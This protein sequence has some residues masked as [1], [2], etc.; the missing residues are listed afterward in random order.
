MACRICL[1]ESG[2]FI[3]PCNCKGTTGKVHTSCLQTWILESRSDRC[4]I[5]KHEYNFKEY[6]V[7]KFKYYLKAL[8]TLKI[9]LNIWL[10]VFLTGMIIAIL[11]VILS[12]SVETREL[13]WVHFTVVVCMFLIS[14]LVNL[15]FNNVDYDV[16][17][18]YMQNIVLIY[19]IFFAGAFL[20]ITDIRKES[21]EYQLDGCNICKTVEDNCD[22]ACEFSYQWK[23]ELEELNETIHNMWYSVGLVLAYK[24][25][26][27]ILNGYKYV[28]VPISLEV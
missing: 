7:Y 15:R 18:V 12:L 1:E 3:S 10:F 25:I 6:S 19:Y 28:H 8:R 20:A 22:W 23:N 24:L 11:T 5:C 27:D 16:P 2:A 9:P 4:E 17:N 14:A 26:L 21:V 13:V